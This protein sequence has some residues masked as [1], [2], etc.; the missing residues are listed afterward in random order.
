M[1]S[2]VWMVV[3]LAAMIGLSACGEKP[4]TAELKAAQDAVAAAKAANADVTKASETLDKAQAEIDAQ[5]KKTFGADYKNAKALLAEAKTLSEK[6]IADKK[7]AD[8]AKAKAEAEAKA[9]AEAEAKAK[10][11]A[12]AKKAPAKKAAAKPDAKAQLEAAK[13]KVE[14]TKTKVEAATKK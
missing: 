7:A 6:A 10:A 8:E 14:D 5:G 2:L 12:A 4:P 11:E 9:K 1:K 13:K 3:V